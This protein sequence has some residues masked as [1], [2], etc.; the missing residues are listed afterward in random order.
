VVS[1][2]SGGH[3]RIEDLGGA[4][5]AMAN[6][7]SAAL[8]ESPKSTDPPDSD[9]PS[10][11]S[12][13]PTVHEG[14]EP[15]AA[16]LA[17]R[18]VGDKR[19]GP[20]VPEE[21]TALAESSDIV[22]SYA[23]FG[24]VMACIL[25]REKDASRRFSFSQR[26]LVD[27][28]RACLKY[29]GTMNGAKMPV[30][31]TLYEVGRGPPSDDD[32]HRLNE[33][34]RT[35]P[36]TTKVTITGCY[37]DTENHT[38]WTTAPLQR[39]LQRVG[40]GGWLSAVLR[41]PRKSDGEIF[42]A[43]PALPSQERRPIATVVLLAFLVALF[44]VE[45]LVRIGEKGAGLLGV[46]AETL[47]ALGGMN[48]DAV[49]KDGQWYRI[50]VAALL[51][52]DL[53]HLL[54]NGLALG[55]SGYL[56]ESMLGRAWFISLFFVGAIGGSLMGLLVNPSNI[57]SVGASGAVMGLL[58]AALVATVR[59]P[60]GATRTQIQGQILQFLI[61]S[62]I[63]LA[64]HRQVGHI[65]FAAHFGGAIVGVVAGYLLTRI[66]PRTEE[67]PRFQRVTTG[68]AVIA[69]ACFALSLW[70]AKGHYSAYST[71]ATSEAVPI[72]FE[73]VGE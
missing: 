61:P 45:H 49:L 4:E 16:Y 3:A 68:F 35:F 52:V 33:L 42:V 28:G 24:L 72:S 63:P 44:V 55:L 50:L 65:D 39:L 73:S 69:L 66:W 13:L 23:D 56:L 31:I 40:Y 38:V 11:G 15:F 37:L 43:D 51:H 2:G 47:F 58:A 6:L 34:R 41:E 8:F 53:F 48:I 57:V 71:R 62:L 21:A 7:A 5:G 36:G 54:L 25:D 20:G 17:K 10:A 22:L 9:D 67:Q 27:I 18:L 26:E 46:D 14:Q 29:T 59:F 32:C 12:R 64:T 19:Y 1:R 70:L 30:G 60:P